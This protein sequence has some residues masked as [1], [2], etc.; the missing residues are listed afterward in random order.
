[1]CMAENKHAHTILPSDKI[2]KYNIKS[3]ALDVSENCY[4][5]KRKNCPRL[6]LCETK[7]LF[8]ILR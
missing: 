4:F 5:G 7:I 6:E 1:M 8:E 2:I 3:E